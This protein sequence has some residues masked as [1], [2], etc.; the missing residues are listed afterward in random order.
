MVIK[1]IKTRFRFDIKLDEEDLY[2]ERSKD[3]LDWS[4]E[5][6]KRFENKKDQ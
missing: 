4:A 1:N 2:N 5:S 3:L 6:N